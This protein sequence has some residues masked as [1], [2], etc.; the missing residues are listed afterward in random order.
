MANS[1]IYP[2]NT[3]GQPGIHTTL[4]FKASGLLDPQELAD[5]LRALGVQD[6]T[7]STVPG[8]EQGPW[9]ACSLNSEGT[10]NLWPDIGIP[11]SIEQSVQ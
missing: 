7:L 9:L 1:M 11:R 10:V 6:P 3:V 2:E 8:T 4:V 5:A